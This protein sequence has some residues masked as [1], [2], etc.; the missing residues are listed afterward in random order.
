MTI[1]IDLIYLASVL[2]SARDLRKLP[3]DLEP[4]T[5]AR[6][7]MAH[8]KIST[9]GKERAPRPT[10]KDITD[11]CDYLDEH[12]TLPM[13]DIIQFAIESAM[14][15][16]EITRLRWIDLNEADR[17]VIIRDRKHPR[18]GHGVFHYSTSENW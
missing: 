17:T 18:H 1:S 4:I 14:H 12:S 8:L 5:S 6:A 13:R 9:K 7:N 10:D 16:D 15:V 11:L 3:I 2:R